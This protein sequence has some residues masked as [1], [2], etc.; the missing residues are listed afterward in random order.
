MRGRGGLAAICCAVM[1]LFALYLGGVSVLLPFLGKTFG[2]G[3]EVEGRLFPAD[4]GGFVVGVVVC[5]YLSDRWGRKAVLLLGLSGYALGLALFGKAPTF[6]LALLAAALF[7]AGSGAME[8]VASALA[9]DLYP[10]RRAFMINAIQVA[11]GVGAAIGPTLAYRLLA[12]GTNWRMLYLGLALANVLLCVALAL[13]SV[14]RSAHGPEALNFRTLLAVLKR[15][16]FGALCLAQGLYVGAETGFFL[17]MPTYFQARLPGGAAWAGLVVTVFW[18]AMTV[19]RV[20]TGALVERMPL[21]RLAQWLAWCGALCSTLALIGSTPAWVMLCVALTGL[22]FSGIYGV[23][24]AETGARFPT[25]AGTAFGGVVAL[26]GLGGAALPWAIGALAA[27]PLDW[28][29]ALALVPLSMA[30]LAL[31]APWLKRS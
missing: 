2:L 12:I 31:I 13:Q 27:T 20:T 15:P 26:G 6:N 14:P 9:S 10:G 8:T 23:V 3:P 17:W 18:L 22:F 29:G 5:G 25:V 1:F 4:F 30:L 21:L 24:L 11:F 28:R 16:A 19:G 7:G